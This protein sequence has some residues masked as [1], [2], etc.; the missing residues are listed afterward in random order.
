MRRPRLAVAALAGAA[1]MAFPAA[2]A[3]RLATSPAATWQAKGSV[4]AI[5][6]AGSVVYV[7]GDF[8]SVVAPRGSKLAPRPR[9]N[10]AAFDLVTHKLLGWRAST[11][12]PVNALA[13]HGTRLYI[14][15][16]FTQVNG[17]KHLRLAAVSLGRGRLAR[18][19][20][21]ADAAVRALIATRTRLYVGGEFHRLAGGDRH[22]LGAVSIGTGRLVRSWHPVV[23]GPVRALALSPRGS[24]LFV[25]GDFK[26]VS[27]VASRHLAAVSTRSGA[28][29]RSWPLHPD[30]P[31]LALAVRRTSLYVGGGGNGG[32]LAAFALPS[33]RRRWTQL[34]DG[35]VA[36]VTVFRSTVYAGGHFDNVC[37]GNK[38]SGNPLTCAD[39]LLRRKLFSASTLSGKVSSWAPDANS[40]LGVRALHAG[41]RSVEAGGYFTA[42]RPGMTGPLISQKGFA[43]FAR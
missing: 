24:R 7:G 31:V 17:R 36:A 18:W 40:P 28:A 13:I 22:R 2:A 25:G 20:A 16:S 15:G 30:Y 26:T 33:A 19:H 4:S 3:A 11:D 6:V 37:V 9:H 23:S 38:G 14:G 29:S 21:A 10:L 42:F 41:R 34:T 27:T 8:S 32:Q 5:A 35:D 39:P 12:G 43:E 1:L